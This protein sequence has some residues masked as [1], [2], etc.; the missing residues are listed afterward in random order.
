[1]NLK[2]AKIENLINALPEN[3]PLYKDGGL[4]AIRSDNMENIYM[5]QNSNETLK[6]FIIRYIEW[7]LEFDGVERDD[8]A[9]NLVI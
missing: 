2:Y 6:D 4:W 8:L 9:Y 7:L 3:R 1:M 5:A